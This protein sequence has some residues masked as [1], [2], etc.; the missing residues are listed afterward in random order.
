MAMNLWNKVQK[1]FG[2][3]SSILN[4]NFLNI[5]STTKC[6]SNKQMF[7]LLCGG[8]DKAFCKQV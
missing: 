8:K 1:T 7:E 5:E 6:V 2:P 3:I 4:I